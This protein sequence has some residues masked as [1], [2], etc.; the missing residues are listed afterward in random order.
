MPDTNKKT[1]VEIPLQRLEN[2]EWLV[3]AMDNYEWHSCRRGWLSSHDAYSE[4]RETFLTARRAV[5]EQ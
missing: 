4:A 1:M 3:E 2:L 5:K